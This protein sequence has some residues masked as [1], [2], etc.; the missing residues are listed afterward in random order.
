VSGDGVQ[1]G[2]GVPID[3]TG[4]VRAEAAR[5]HARARPTHKPAVPDQTPGGGGCGG[6]RD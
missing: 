1:R 2:G 3:T 4:G 5:V 6:R